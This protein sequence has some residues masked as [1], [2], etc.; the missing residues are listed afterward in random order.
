MLKE[1]YMPASLETTFHPI[2]SAP[3][4]LCSELK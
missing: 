2:R 1:A 3:T 4:E